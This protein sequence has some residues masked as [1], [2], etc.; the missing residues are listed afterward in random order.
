MVTNTAERLEQA[1]ATLNDLIDLTRGGCAA[2]IRRI[3]RNG[4]AA[5]VD[6]VKGVSDAEL[7]RAVRTF[8]RTNR[9]SQPHRANARH[10][11]T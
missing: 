9:K 5:F 2:R 10:G 7:R 4:E 6:D 1:V 3:P 8:G 11:G